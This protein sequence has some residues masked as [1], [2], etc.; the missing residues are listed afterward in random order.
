MQHHHGRIFLAG[1]GRRCGENIAGNQ[2]LARRVIDELD[3]DLALL[4]QEELG[5]DILLLADIDLLLN[6]LQ[7]VGDVLGIGVG[8]FGQGLGL[9]LSLGL[10]TGGRLDRRRLGGGGGLGQ[11]GRAAQ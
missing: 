5:P 8:K 6:L 11:D 2:V 7:P 10:R 9:R 3:M 1:H 4:L